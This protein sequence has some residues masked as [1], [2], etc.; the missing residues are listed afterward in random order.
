MKIESVS[1]KAET[2]ALA[3]VSSSASISAL[4]VVNSP[5]TLEIIKC[6]TLKVI[7]LCVGSNNHLVA[8]IFNILLINYSAN[9]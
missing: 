1:M 7:S 9:L 5:F 2:F 3:N 4:K 8:I 6:F